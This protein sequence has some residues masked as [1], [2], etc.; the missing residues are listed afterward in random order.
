MW[1]Q[2]GRRILCVKHCTPLGRSHM[3]DDQILMMTLPNTFESIMALPLEEA[4]SLVV[5]VRKRINEIELER[6]SYLASD[7]KES[8][9]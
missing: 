1:I 4:Q 6:K 8:L 7:I 5:K 3:C 9:R 2:R